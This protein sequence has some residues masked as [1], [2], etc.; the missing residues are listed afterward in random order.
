MRLLNEPDCEL[1]LGGNILL[2][3]AIAY[4]IYVERNEISDFFTGVFEGRD[5]TVRAH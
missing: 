5:A 3:G 1:V 4:G 2:L